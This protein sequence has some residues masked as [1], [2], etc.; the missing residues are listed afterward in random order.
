[1]DSGSV[2]FKP[3]DVNFEPLK[4]T[5]HYVRYPPDTTTV[6]FLRL[7]FAD[8]NFYSVYD[9]L[10]LNGGVNKKP[11]HVMVVNYAK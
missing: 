8:Q 7:F 11:L 1:V 9:S 6:P 5:P 2:S 3:L 4:P 10:V